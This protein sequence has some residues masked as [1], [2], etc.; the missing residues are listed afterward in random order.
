[1][2]DADLSDLQGDEVAEA[3]EAVARLTL[4]QRAARIDGRLVG[5][6]GGGG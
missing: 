2:A 3:H 6:L 4:R 5:S 1:M